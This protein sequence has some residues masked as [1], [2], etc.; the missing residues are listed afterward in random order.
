[1][2]IEPLMCSVERVT[3]LRIVIETPARPAVRV[4]AQGAIPRE[5]AFV[6]GVLVA[7]R[8]DARRVFERSRAMAFLT[9][10]DRMT[11]DQWKSR[12]IVIEGH[13]PAPTR[14]LVALLAAG[15]QLGLMGIVLLVAGD[16]GCC[17]LVAI[18]VASV[19][20]VAFDLGVLPAQRKLGHSVVTEFHRLPLGRGV[21]G[22]ALGTVASRMSVL[23]AMAGDAGRR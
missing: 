8:T 15:T 2:T 5:S 4:V 21:A 13:L 14:L 12:D 9:G 18:K 7:A 10:R 3:C 17:E 1:M 11:A 23:Q 6:M 19:T 16:A 22:L 20:G